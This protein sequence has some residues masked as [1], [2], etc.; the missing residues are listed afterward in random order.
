MMMGLVVRLA[1]ALKLHNMD[2]TSL[3]SCCVDLG[4]VWHAAPK[5]LVSTLG[6]IISIL[7]IFD[8]MNTDYTENC[9][10]PGMGLE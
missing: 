2:G 4:D 7:P 6:D 9:T 3:R 1:M 10:L 8:K 5:T